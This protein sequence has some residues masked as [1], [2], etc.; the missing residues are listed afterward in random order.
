MANAPQFTN[1][2]HI[3]YITITSATLDSTA[4]PSFVAFTAATGGSRVDRITFTNAGTASVASANTLCKVWISDNVGAN[5]KIYQE[6][7]MTGATRSATQ[8][9]ARSQITFS[10]G[11]ILQGGQKI[12]VG[13]AYWVTG[14]TDN[15]SVITEGGDFV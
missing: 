15:L 6:I 13:S 11:L 5:Y 9:G 2:P 10:G 4:T 7:A 12:G 8:I 14:T 3:E 1:T